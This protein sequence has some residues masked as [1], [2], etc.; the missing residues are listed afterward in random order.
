MRC[1]IYLVIASER[2]NKSLERTELWYL[3]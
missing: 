3:R 1:S 2:D